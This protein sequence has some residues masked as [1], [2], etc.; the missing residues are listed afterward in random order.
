MNSVQ[1]ALV[2]ALPARRKNASKGWISFNAPCC[3]HNGETPDRRMRGGLLINPDG[4]FSYHCFNCQYKASW[5]PGYHLGYRVRRLLSWFGISNDQIQVLVFDA[6]RQLDQEIVLVE[7][8]KKTA[9]FKPRPLP[10][11]CLPI[12]EWLQADFGEDRDLKNNLESTVEYLISRGF[13]LDD[14]NWHWSP[15]SKNQ[16]NRR[17]VIPFTWQNQIIGFTARS[18]NPTSK[19]KYFNSFESDYVFNT[20]AQTQDR[21]FVVVVEGPFD[22]IAVDGVAV[23]TND[24]NE[25]KAEIIEGLGKEVI[26]VPDQ[27]RTGGMLIDSA[28][29]YGW[30]VSFP[31]WQNDIKDCA[32]AMQRYG[33]LYTLRSILEGKQTS[34]L[35]IEL[36][37]KQ[38]GI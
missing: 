13:D 37:R 35:K 24:I 5:K 9:E 7:R 21:K 20:D 15:D 26:V 2:S 8:N 28:I 10:D 19:L 11:D 22:A 38:H 25:N 29:K 36:L 31:L 27:D 6:M 1:Q 33:K 23:L 18:I 12:Q 17:V 3:V 32:A 30:N 14:Y 16:I 4:G 34:A